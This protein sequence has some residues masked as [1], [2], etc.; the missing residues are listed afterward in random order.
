M[1][2]E[3]RPEP[4]QHS[5]SARTRAWRIALGAVAGLAAV[6]ML[7]WAVVASLPPPDAKRAREIVSGEAPADLRGSG[8]TPAAP[9][10]GVTP[11]PARPAPSQQGEAF[12]ERFDRGVIA[13]RWFISDGWSNGSWMSNDWR[14]T[15]VEVRPGMMS[16]HLRKGPKASAYELAS[17]EARTHDFLRY[18]YFEVQMK[19]PQGAGLVTGVFSYADR[20]KGVKP[21]EIDIEILGRNTRVVELTIHEGGRATTKNVTLPFDAADGF[22]TYGFDWQPGFVRWYADGRLIHE[23]TGPAARNLTRPQQ[24]ILNLW[25]SRE[26]RSWVG[27][28]DIKQGPWRLDFSCVA[29]APTY[30]GSLCA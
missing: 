27:P 21:N 7:A 25:A 13:D 1:T 14:R 26:L 12:I 11:A 30:A 10:A 5:S 16:L 6:A 23:E 15:E 17:G 19:V 22:H 9:G 2:G 20:A 28:L 29:Y 8:R 24:L 18:G 3:N 4:G